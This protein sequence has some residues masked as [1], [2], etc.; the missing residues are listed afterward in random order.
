VRPPM[1]R[2]HLKVWL[3]LPGFRSDLAIFVNPSASGIMLDATHYDT[4]LRRHAE[5]TRLTHD[6]RADRP[7]CGVRR[8]LE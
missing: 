5:P 3:N 8:T 1:R 2:R 4:L 6:G 7:G